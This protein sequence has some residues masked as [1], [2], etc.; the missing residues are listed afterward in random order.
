MTSDDTYV[1]MAARIKLFEKNL[2][3]GAN[4]PTVNVSVTHNRNLN[5]ANLIFWSV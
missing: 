1:P 3:N 2:G 4:R 5:N